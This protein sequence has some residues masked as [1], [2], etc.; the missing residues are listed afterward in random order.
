MYNDNWPLSIDLWL[1][2]LPCICYANGAAIIM[3][4]TNAKNDNQ[5]RMIWNGSFDIGLG[6]NL[7]ININKDCV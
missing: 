1:C 4:L 2:Q 5:S 7:K 6:L 3:S